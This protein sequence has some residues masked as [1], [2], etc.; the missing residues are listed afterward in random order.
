MTTCDVALLGRHAAASCWLVEEWGRLIR[1]G[2]LGLT[3]FD[4]LE[5]TK[6]RSLLDAID[7]ERKAVQEAVRLG[8]EWVREGTLLDAIG[9]CAEDFVHSIPDDT[10]VG[11][12]TWERA[13]AAFYDYTQ[14]VSDHLEATPKMFRFTTAGTL[15]A[16]SDFVSPGVFTR[17]PPLETERSLADVQDRLVSIVGSA[18]WDADLEQDVRRLGLEVAR[19][20]QRSA[21]QLLAASHDALRTPSGAEVDPVAV[22]IPLREAVNRSLADLLQ[23]RP[24]Q[25]PTPRVSDKVRSICEQL[26]R[27]NLPHGE[28]ERLAEEARR[29][30]DDLSAAKQD[31][32]RSVETRA[33]FLRGKAFLRALLCAVDET[34]LRP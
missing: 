1:T 13:T 7:K 8:Q 19:A 9:Q 6:K 16:V 17:P 18:S 27:P 30:S 20:D 31:A 23:R 22:L 5:E 15:S 32:L 3:M 2:S 12:E 28:I 24:C 26:G 33:L 11:A 25:E 4:H 21:L 14:V 10:Y 34:R 29:L